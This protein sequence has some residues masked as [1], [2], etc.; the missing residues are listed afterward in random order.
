MPDSSRPTPDGAA[1]THGL[2]RPGD[3]RL[4]PASTAEAETLAPVLPPREV[5][6]GASA[7]TLP[8]ARGPAEA[9][10]PVAPDVPGHEILGELGRGAMGVVNSVN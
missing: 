9:A 1:D 5:V 3:G 2:V 10:D 4:V 6:F 7:A 8:P